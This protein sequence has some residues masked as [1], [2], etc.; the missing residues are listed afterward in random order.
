[1]SELA[2]VHLELAGKGVTR[3]WLWQEYEAPQ[4]QSLSERQACRF[5]THAVPL[6]VFGS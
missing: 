3:E 5:V 4:A 2:K 1:M 6:M